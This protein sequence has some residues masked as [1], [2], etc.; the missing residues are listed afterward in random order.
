MILWHALH[1]MSERK[2][3]AAAKC[4]DSR[5]FFFFRFLWTSIR[6][7]HSIIFL[8]VSRFSPFSIQ[9]KT[10]TIFPVFMH[11]VS[12][13]WV[14][15]VCDACASLS[16]QIGFQVRKCLR[17]TKPNLI[18]GVG[19]FHV[20]F[21]DVFRLHR[22]F[23]RLHFILISFRLPLRGVWGSCIHRP[24]FLLSHAALKIHFSCSLSLCL[25]SF[26][27]NEYGNNMQNYPKMTLNS[28]KNQRY[29][30]DFSAMRWR[31]HCLNRQWREWDG[32]H[33]KWIFY[34]E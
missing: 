4:V 7:L 28:V 15:S 25:L 26:Y 16:W 19:G 2:I 5:D 10:V 3:D 23:I 27:A 9:L 1:R 29:T 30:T 8:F 32:D 33:A 14:V 31:K 6:F 22:S 11:C 12:F 13:V 21:D 18:G 24:V 20:N 34:A 17:T